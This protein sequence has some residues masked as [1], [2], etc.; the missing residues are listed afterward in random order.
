[1]DDPPVVAEVIK[2]VSQLSS[3]KASGA[4]TMPAEIY[5]VSGPVFKE[6]FTELV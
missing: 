1:M 2:A 3:G 6:K 4:A 5:K